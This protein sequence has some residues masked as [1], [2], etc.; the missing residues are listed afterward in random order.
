MAEVM[1]SHSLVKL[2]KQARTSDNQ[3]DILT[4]HPQSA[5]YKIKQG[6]F[7]LFGNKKQK[8]KWSIL[9]ATTAT[10]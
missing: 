1:W 2:N 3:K 6:F 7:S 9:K 5:I 8:Q 4:F 10:M